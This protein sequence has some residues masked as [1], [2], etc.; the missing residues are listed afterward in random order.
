[1]REGGGNHLGSLK[2]V[3]KTC[4]KQAEAIAVTTY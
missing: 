3:L 2:A 1:M 4:L